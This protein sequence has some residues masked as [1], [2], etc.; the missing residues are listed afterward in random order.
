MPSGARPRPKRVIKALSTNPGFEPGSIGN[1]L[2]PFTLDRSS[3]ILWVSNSNKGIQKILLKVK[4]YSQYNN[5]EKHM[6][7]YFM[8]LN[9]SLNCEPTVKFDFH[10]NE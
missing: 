5:L 6:F 10:C 9:Y 1:E 2:L 8:T 4:N 7:N 3:V